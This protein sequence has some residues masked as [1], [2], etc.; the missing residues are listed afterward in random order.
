MNLGEYNATAKNGQ[1][2]VWRNDEM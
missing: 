2:N 1:T